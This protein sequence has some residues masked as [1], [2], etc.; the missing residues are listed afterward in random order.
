MGMPELPRAEAHR[1]AADIDESI[2][3]AKAC[4]DWLTT[5]ASLRLYDPEWTP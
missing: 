2:A 3:H 4:R 1:A 5:D